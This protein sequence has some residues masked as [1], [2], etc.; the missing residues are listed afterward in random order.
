MTLYFTGRVITCLSDG[1]SHIPYKDSKLT[2]LLQD[3]LGGNSKTTLLATIAPS[4]CKLRQ[5]TLTLDYA[6]KAKN[7]KNKPMVSKIKLINCH[8]EVDALKL[9]IEQ[10]H[11]ILAEKDAEL[12]IK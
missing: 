8:Q 2:Q 6:H 12:R 9:V 11:K 1:A 10:E 4:S 3:S 7:I 5:T